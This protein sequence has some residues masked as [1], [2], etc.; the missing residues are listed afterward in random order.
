MAIWGHRI[1]ALIGLPLDKNHEC[2]GHHTRL[3]EVCPAVMNIVQVFPSL[4][5]WVCI[6]L[7]VESVSLPSVVMWGD[8]AG[9]RCYCLS[10][11]WN[12][13]G[14]CDLQ[15]FWLV[16]LESTKNW[17]LGVDT[18]GQQV[19]P[20]VQYETAWLIIKDVV[21]SVPYSDKWEFGIVTRIGSH[22]VRG[23]VVPRLPQKTLAMLWYYV[24]SC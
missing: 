10:K 1:L 15:G 14:G 5:Y 20:C 7:S 9:I 12:S 19:L 21:G 11:V 4:W 18:P 16:M 8:S 23:V 22:G 6:V 17:V 3:R 13:G 24:L 2:H